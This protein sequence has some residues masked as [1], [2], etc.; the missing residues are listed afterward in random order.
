[1]RATIEARDYPRF[2]R[3]VQ[4]VFGYNSKDMV[5]L[6][7]RVVYTAWQYLSKSKLNNYFFV[8][9]SD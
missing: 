5:F 2:S 3:Q 7:S 8:L 6:P 4:Q 9:M 1:V